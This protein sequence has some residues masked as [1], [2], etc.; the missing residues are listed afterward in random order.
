VTINASFLVR[1]VSESCTNISEVYE[2]ETNVET[3]VA[4]LAYMS[5]PPELQQLALNFLATFLRLFSLVVALNNNR[6]RHTSA[7]AQKMFTLPS[8]RP[9]SIREPP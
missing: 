4:A 7:R 2:E 8:M 1:A 6:H 5:P 3:A 9:M